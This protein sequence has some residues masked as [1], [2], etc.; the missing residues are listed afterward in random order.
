MEKFINHRLVFAEYE[1]SNSKTGTLQMGPKNKSGDFLESGM[2][3][4]DKMLGIYG[5]LLSK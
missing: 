1:S 2:R 3:N 5:D 4:I